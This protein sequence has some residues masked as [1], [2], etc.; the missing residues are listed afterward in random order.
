MHKASEEL[1]QLW[2]E[3]L[4]RQPG[5]IKAAFASLNPSNQKVVLA[6]LQRMVSE[7][8]WQPEQNLSARAA[9]DVLLSPPE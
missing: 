7:P 1:E 6:H 9:L 5:T 4:S 2:E 3:L 8:G